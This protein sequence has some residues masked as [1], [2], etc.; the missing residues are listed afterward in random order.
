MGLGTCWVGYFNEDKVKKALGLPE[1]V[2]ICNL[3]P[4]GYAAADATPAKGHTQ[5]RP[6]EEM[7][8]FL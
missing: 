5:C 1:E 3:L 4:A 2:R 8:R 7:V 6:A